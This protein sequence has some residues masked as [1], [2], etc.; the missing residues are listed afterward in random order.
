MVC[1]YHLDRDRKR[2]NED[3]FSQLVIPQALKF[4]V[5][6]N[7]HDHVSG[8]HFGVHKTFQKA[9][10]RLT[11]GQACSKTLSTGVS[12]ARIAQ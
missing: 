12:L 7:V 2:R 4:E 9:K 11:G 1:F 10:Q 6:S 5:L 8:G 3:P